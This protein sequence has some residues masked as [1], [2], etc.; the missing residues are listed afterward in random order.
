VKPIKQDRRAV[1]TERAG[2]QKIN[3]LFQ[4]IQDEAVSEEVGRR[5]G[6][7][8]EEMDAS[9]DEARSRLQR[10]QTAAGRISRTGRD[11]CDDTHGQEGVYMLHEVQCTR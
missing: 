9:T 11:D 3:K 7:L 10:K 5:A 4:C 1:A 8:F 6:K 2:S